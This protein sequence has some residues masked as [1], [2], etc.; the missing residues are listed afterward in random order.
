MDRHKLRKMLPQG[1]LKEVAKEAEVSNS[2]VTNYFK[3]RNNSYKIE[4]AAMI[5]AK[6][7]EVQ[8]RSLSNEL[9]G[10]GL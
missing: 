4:I 2:A 3:G 8:R 6:K 9:L 7:Y 1:A 10:L 5:I